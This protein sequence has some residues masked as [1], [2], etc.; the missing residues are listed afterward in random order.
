MAVIF[1]IFHETL[2]NMYRVLGIVSVNI[3]QIKM[4]DSVVQNFHVFTNFFDLVFLSIL[5]MEHQNP[6]L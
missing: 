2:K 5:V 6:V 4:V 3:N 1:M